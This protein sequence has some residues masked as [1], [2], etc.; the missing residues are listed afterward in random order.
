MKV[1]TIQ[2]NKTIIIII[3]VDTEFFCELFDFSDSFDF[4]GF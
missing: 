1:K 4:S 3:P 2:L